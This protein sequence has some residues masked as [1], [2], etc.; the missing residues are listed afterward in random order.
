MAKVYSTFK[1]EKA[2]KLVNR[3]KSEG[4]DAFVVD[5]SKRTPGSRIG[6]TVHEVPSV[7]ITDDSQFKSAMKIIG[8]FDPSCIKAMSESDIGKISIVKIAVV[9]GAMLV[10]SIAVGVLWSWG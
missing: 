3:L 6:L 8:S 2:E 9:M 7:F 5:Y 1:L 10:F 4:I